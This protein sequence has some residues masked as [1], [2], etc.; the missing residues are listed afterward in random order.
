MPGMNRLREILDPLVTML[1]A[2]ACGVAL[3]AFILAI[4]VLL[5]FFPG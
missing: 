3:V 4:R 5:L 2:A 1:L